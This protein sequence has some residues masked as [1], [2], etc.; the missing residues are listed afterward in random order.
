LTRVENLNFNVTPDL[1][2]KSVI[3]C[4]QNA[5]KVDVSRLSKKYESKVVVVTTGSNGN[6][7]IQATLKKLR[8][9]HAQPADY[10]LVAEAEKEGET[11]I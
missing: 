10:T 6:D 7:V 2:Q 5:L 1:F 9:K 3:V 11:E 4:L 8:M